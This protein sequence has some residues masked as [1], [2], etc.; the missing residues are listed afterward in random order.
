MPDWEQLVMKGICDNKYEQL[1]WKQ[2]K[3]M[4]GIDE[5]GR[6]PLAGPLV[7]A[8]VVFPLNYSNN[9]IYDSKALSAKKREELFT[10]INNDAL[11]V[12]IEIIDN[13]A[14]DEDNIYAITQKTMLK[15]ANS[16]S[17]IFVLTDAMPL[18]RD[19]YEHIIKADQHSISVAAA[20][21]IAKVTRDRIMDE[22]DV[23]YPQY[24][25][26]HNKGYGTKKHLEAIQQYGVTPI[27]RLSYKPCSKYQQLS[28]F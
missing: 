2:N 26:K 16:V 19:N 12:I 1:L 25:F 15:I 13:K 7:V 28:F 20:S 5:A 14:I 24:D 10:V 22:Y 21:I 17:D 6:G 27:H 18:N 8:G 23:L 4:C 9:E 3:L 11:K